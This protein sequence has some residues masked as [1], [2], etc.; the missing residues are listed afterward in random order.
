MIAL[1]LDD[2]RQH[3]DRLH[4]R[5][6]K[7]VTVR[8]VEPRDAD[9][10]RP[11]APPFVVGDERRVELTGNHFAGLALLGHLLIDC[12]LRAPEPRAS[13]VD[14]VVEQ[15]AAGVEGCQ[16][17]VEGLPRLHQLEL[18]ILQV[19]LQPSELVD[20]GLHRLELSR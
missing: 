17:G 2:L 8:F 13:A 15:G 12:D 4:L 7:S 10:L 16:I 9:A 11:H 19:L 6:G 1:R 5:S 14:L 20:V 3:S 18:A